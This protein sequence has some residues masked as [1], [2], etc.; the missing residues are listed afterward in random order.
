[1]F[2]SGK[3][4]MALGGSYESD[5]IRGASGWEGEE[6]L[7]R[8]GC[9]PPPAAPGNRPVSTVGGSSYVI[10]RQCQRPELVMDILKVATDPDVV[11]DLY[12]SMLEDSPSSS[13][14]GFLSPEAEPLLTKI[15]RMIASGR[16]RPSIPE[17]FKVSHQLQ[18]MFE[19]AISSTT[20]VDEIVRRT[21][22]FI[23]VISG[24]ALGH[25]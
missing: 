1:L 5:L 24:H 13:F 8:L 4:A 19:A 11:G 10:P 23:G 12:S 7:Q 16:A 17:Y 3:V 20:A 15:S 9:V 21:A 2:A 14:D 25:P 22:E 6:L 18:V